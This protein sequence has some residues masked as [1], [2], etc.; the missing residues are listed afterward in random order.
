MKRFLTLNYIGTRY[1]IMCTLYPNSPRLESEAARFNNVVWPWLQDGAH[2]VTFFR[3]WG[4]FVYYLLWPI[5]Q[6]KR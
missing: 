1:Q 6:I 5:R 3:G 2:G 4:W